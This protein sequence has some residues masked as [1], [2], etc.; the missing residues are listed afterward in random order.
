MTRR[1]IITLVLASMF[2]LVLTAACSTIS[3]MSEMNKASSMVGEANAANADAAKSMDEVNKRFAQLF[4][5]DA[6]F[7][8]RKKFEPTAK[9]ALDSLDKAHAKLA[10]GIQKLDS[11]AKLN[12]EDWYREYISLF[13]QSYRNSDQQNDVLRDMVK[14]YMDYSLDVQALQAR[15]KELSDKSDALQKASA[16]IDAKIKKIEADHK[17]SFK[18]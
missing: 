16:D 11:A 1:N 8:D 5:N 12:I 17:D 13:S 4:S 10:D 14:V 18:S 2:A 6:D 7:N 15:Y 3:K 9:D